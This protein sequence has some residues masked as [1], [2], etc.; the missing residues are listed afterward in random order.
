[1]K[2]YSFEHIS[3]P[4]YFTIIDNKVVIDVQSMEEEFDFK[5]NDLQKSLK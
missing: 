5:V 2:K 1:M 3:V 4:V